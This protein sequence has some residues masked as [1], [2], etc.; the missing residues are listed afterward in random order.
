MCNFLYQLYLY[1]KFL[2]N[3]RGAK[4][5]YTARVCNNAPPPFSSIGLAFRLATPSPDKIASKATTWRCVVESNKI[6]KILQN[7]PTFFPPSIPQSSPLLDRRIGLAFANYSPL[8]SPSEWL[9]RSSI[10]HLSC[11]L[12]AS[13]NA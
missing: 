1:I 10:I 4:S 3:E 2:T 6:S 11:P 12:C 7:P 8:L 9:Q 13:K 5:G